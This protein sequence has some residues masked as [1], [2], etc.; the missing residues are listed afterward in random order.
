MLTE[1][2]FGL[3][4][5][6]EKIQVRDAGAGT[7]RLCER[8]RSVVRRCCGVCRVLSTLIGFGVQHGI[9][10]RVRRCGVPTLV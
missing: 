6:L 4:D 10:Q 2:G 8:S 1:S 3:K 5:C 9:I 7:K